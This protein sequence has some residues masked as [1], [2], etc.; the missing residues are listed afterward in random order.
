MEAKDNLLGFLELAGDF[1]WSFGVFY[2]SH[3]SIFLFLF[4]ELR[5]FFLNGSC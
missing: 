1:G 5:F 2:G 4:C 3:I